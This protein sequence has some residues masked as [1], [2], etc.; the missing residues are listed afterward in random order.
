[1][2]R[3]FKNNTLQIPSHREKGRFVL[4]WRNRVVGHEVLFTREL[5]K[6][7]IRIIAETTLT[8]PRLELRQVVTADF[9]AHLRP[10]H[11]VLISEINQR[12]LALDLRIGD[13]E[14]CAATRLGRKKES[15]TIPFRGEP[16]LLLEHCFALHTVAGHVARRWNGRARS[17]V[18]IP[19]F[20]PLEVILGN[21]DQ[22][23][24]G[25]CRFSPPTVSLELTSRVR[26]HIWMEEGWAK[27]VALPAAHL[28][29][30]WR[31]NRP[32]GG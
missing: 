13:N 25:G 7:S 21:G 29:A 23:L 5:P 4:L 2:N 24:M 30:E 17:F 12:R 27:R 10:R 18:A 9:D 32:N 19:I 22:I 28:R 31:E 26:E 3:V 15:K 14:V 6:E 1:M 11:C 20:E 8:V 16:L